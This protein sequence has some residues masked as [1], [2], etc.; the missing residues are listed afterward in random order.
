[1]VGK[2]RRVKIKQNV[3]EHP[4]SAV[5]D[6]NNTHAHTLF[7]WTFQ[8]HPGGNEHIPH[9][10]AGTRFP[11]LCVHA[12]GRWWSCDTSCDWEWQQV[13]SVWVS[14]SSTFVSS[15]TLRRLR[16]RLSDV[17]CAD[18]WKTKDT[19]NK[20][21]E[22]ADGRFLLLSQWS[23]WSIKSLNRSW[24]QTKEHEPTFSFPPSCGSP[25]HTVWFCL[26]ELLQWLKH[27]APSGV[28]VWWWCW[29]FRALGCVDSSLFLYKGQTSADINAPA[30][31]CAHLVD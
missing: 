3:W 17:L 28:S 12:T 8:K 13:K 4:D 22:A 24:R 16:T 18:S 2:L 10:A 30:A 26:T 23:S 29:T 31:L 21:T 25:P 14:V 9:A 19:K 6:V 1:M 11:L 7:S 15:W 20:A 27:K 5:A